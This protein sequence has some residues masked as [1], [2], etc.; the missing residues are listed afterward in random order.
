MK[1][2]LNCS[3]IKTLNDM[4]GEVVYKVVKELVGNINPIGE[5][6]E[7]NKR[8]ENLKELIHV[9]E[10]LITDIDDMAFRNRDMREHSIKRAVDEA[11]EFIDKIGTSNQ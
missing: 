9:V 1:G 5:T 11:R 2:V 7:D 8:Y 3:V 10:N 6:N 4:N